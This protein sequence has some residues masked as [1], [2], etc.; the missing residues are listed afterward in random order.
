MRCKHTKKNGETCKTNAMQNGYC[1]FHNPDIP[2]S[3]K[4]QA[5]TKGGKSNKVIKVNSP[6]PEFKFHNAKDV[7]KLLTTLINEVLNKDLDLRI[8][9]GITYITNVI[10]KAF[11]QTELSEKIDNIEQLL[12]DYE[13]K[14][15]N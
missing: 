3:E 12:I 1:Y 2:E 6:F 11:E 13:N 15:T 10:L 4:K 5:V 14:K 8:A 7:T 9:T